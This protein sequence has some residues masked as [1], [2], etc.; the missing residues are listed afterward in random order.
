M[1]FPALFRQNADGEVEM[2]NV[3]WNHLK[4]G[5]RAP[6]DFAEVVLSA[7]Y[8]TQRGWLVRGLGRLKH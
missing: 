1:S 8:T 7:C 5:T 2:L 4:D 3:R 6:N